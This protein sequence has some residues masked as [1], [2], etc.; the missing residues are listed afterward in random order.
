MRL[1]RKLLLIAPTI[2]LLFVFAGMIY[3][4]MQMRVM[5][6]GS[7]SLKQRTDYVTA[8]QRGEKQLEPGRAIGLLQLALDVEAKRTAAITA[9]HDLLIT[10]SVVG[11]IACVV[12][13]IGI[14]GVPR[15]HWPRVAFERSQAG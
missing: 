4:A 7:D 13:V 2:V 8:I 3:T 10:L 5:S 11:L 9:S 15:E 14:R 1:D 6:L 12:L